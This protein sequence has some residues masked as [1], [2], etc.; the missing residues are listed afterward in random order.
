MKAGPRARLPEHASD[1][2]A[3][4]DRAAPEGR[5]VPLRTC[6]GCRRRGPRSVL[7][8]VVV[9]RAG[10]PHAEVDDA[11]RAPGRGA[12]LHADLH[13][14]ELAE[15]R[16]GFARALRTPDLDLAPVRARLE[17]GGLV[18]ESAR[19]SFTE[20]ESGLESDGYPMSTQR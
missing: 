20:M 13:C 15:R 17:Q 3:V 18:P 5:H 10:S 11:R 8:R 12:W 19:P 2:P 7:V 4:A 1:G 9:V 6:V 14:L 16:R